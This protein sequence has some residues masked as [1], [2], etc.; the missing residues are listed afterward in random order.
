MY[1]R[2]IT[3]AIGTA[4]TKY[5]ALGLVGPRQSGKT[6][7]AKLV[8]P[9]HEYISLENPDHRAR[10]IDDPRLFLKSCTRSTILDEVQNTPLIF[11]YLQEILDNKKDERQFI[12]TGSNSFQLNE[13]ISQ[14][15]AGRIRIFEILPLLFEE[16]PQTK[17]PKTLDELLV[18]G[19][20]PRIYD[21]NL[22]AYEWFQGYYQTYL[23]KDIKT[24]INVSDTNQFD[25]FV[26]LCA[27]RIAQLG[28][29]SS[30]AT[31]VGVS[32]P[33]AVRWASVLESSFITFRLSPHFTNF[34]KR[35]IKT[36]KIYFYDTGLVCQLLRIRSSD[37]LMV[38]PM[39]GAIFENY[40]VA[41]FMKFYSSQGLQPP[42]Y[43]WRDIHGHE[44]D[45]L[46]DRGSDFSALEIKSG[47]TFQDSWTKSLVWFAALQEKPHN[48]LVYGGDLA[49]EHRGMKVYTWQ[50]IF[51]LANS[52]CN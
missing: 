14:S 43:F 8:F 5:R 32:Q 49:F 33:T 31:E 38:H 42:L 7:L 25:R 40:V 41:E 39:R 4:A 6:T 20:Y 12:L 48:L 15:L 47:S 30:V 13:K 29:Y 11:S 19:L 50:N 2:I 27:G 28:E 9:Q 37:Q 21:Q 24:I 16:L 3:T 1:T 35:V 22:D 10:A 17:R 26:R 45:L 34:N 36:S 23:Q 52:L 46:V 44:I 18:T 51:A